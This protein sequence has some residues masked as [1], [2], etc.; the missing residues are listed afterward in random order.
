MLADFSIE[1]L[2]ECNEQTSPKTEK[3]YKFQIKYA[4]MYSIFWDAELNVNMKLAQ[5]LCMSEI[6]EEFLLGLMFVL[7]WLIS[8]PE[9]VLCY[10]SIKSDIPLIRNNSGIC[11]F[12]S[13]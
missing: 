7:L 6:V 3:D 9:N 13:Y 5:S 2:E 8:I 11:S 12:C 4:S 10:Q 1:Y